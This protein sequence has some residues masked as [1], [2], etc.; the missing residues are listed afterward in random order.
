[1]NRIQL[2][3]TYQLYN[4]FLSNHSYVSF[5]FFGKEFQD[6][7]WLVNKDNPYFQIIRVTPKNQIDINN[8]INRIQTIKQVFSNEF[9][10]ENLKFLDL[11]IGLEEAY[12]NYDF[13]VVVIEEDY[14]SGKELNNIFPG[15]YNVIHNVKDTELEIKDLLESINISTRKLKLL[16]KNK[17]QLLKKQ[18]GSKIVVLGLI[19]I[20]VIM[21]IISNLFS[22][23]YSDSASLIYLGADYKMFTLGL[24]QYWRLITYSFLHGSLVHLIS[25]CLSLYIIG[26]ILESRLGHIKFLFIYFIG[27]LSAALVHGVLLGNSLAIGMSGGIYALF[28]YFIIYFMSKRMVN[29][30]SLLPTIFINIAIN[31]LPGVSWQGHL[32]GAIIGLLCFYILE[33]DKTNYYILP[34]VFLLLIGMFVKYKMDF[35]IKP[36]YIATDNEVLNI[37]ESLGKNDKA[38]DL[39][40]KLY[41]IYTNDIGGEND[42]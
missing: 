18:F 42:N 24:G 26:S 14:H 27:V 32:G 19:I 25:N 29:I 7:L 5:S 41:Y 15:I 23:K 16:S 8:D 2:C 10:N 17:K 33:D 9:K 1:M 20:A 12:S 13:D 31:F 4:F 22:L 21:F 3:K 6:E 28:I 34:V 30:T 36:Y 39:K 38:L 35:Y 11:H 40:N 37:Y